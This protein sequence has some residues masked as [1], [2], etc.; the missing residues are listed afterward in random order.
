VLVGRNRS[1]MHH[2]R[3]S[4]WLAA[5]GWCVTLIVTSATVIYLVQT[6]TGHFSS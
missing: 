3:V 5:A 2:R 6:L 1:I 4:G